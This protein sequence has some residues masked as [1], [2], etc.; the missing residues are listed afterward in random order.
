[1]DMMNRYPH[2]RDLVHHRAGIPAH[3][4][5]KTETKIYIIAAIVFAI[6]IFFA[7]ILS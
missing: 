6:W 5:I 3:N 4:P 7:V 2:I 1:M